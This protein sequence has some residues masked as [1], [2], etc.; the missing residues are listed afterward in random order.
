M[1]R[2]GLNEYKTAAEI[3]MKTIGIILYI[4]AIAAA[5]MGI[6]SYW[7]DYTY[8]KA[9]IAVP[10]RVYDVTMEPIRSGLSNLRYVL[11]YKRN[12]AVDTIRFKVTEQFTNEN[13]LPAPDQLRAATWYVHYVPEAKKTQTV[14]PERKY[15]TN[16]GVY[17]GFNAGSLAPVCT[18]AILGFMFN[19]FRS[20]KRIS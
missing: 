12:G 11:V 5:G 6:R 14:F 16:D 1:N 3:Q 7:R 15:V 10:A 4:A 20:G 8:K 19:R 13:P 18:L 17:P 2:F 9:S